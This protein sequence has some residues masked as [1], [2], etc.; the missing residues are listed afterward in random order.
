[1]E[2]HDSLIL[3]VL[4]QRRAIFN[5]F[6]LAAISLGP[7]SVGSPHG[8]IFADNSTLPLSLIVTSFGP[9]RGSGSHFLAVYSVTAASGTNREASR[10]VR[11]ELGALFSPLPGPL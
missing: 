11:P 5:Q 10:A 4:T 6:G 9:S 7:L 3:P 1:M 2:M 8:L